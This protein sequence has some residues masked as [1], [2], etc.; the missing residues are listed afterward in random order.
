MTATPAAPDPAAARLL[1]RGRGETALGTSLE[2]AP[3]VSLVL[4]ACD[5]DASPLLLLSDL[6]QHTKNMAADG[7]VSLLF[8][9]TGGLADPLTGARLT[10][11]GRAMRYDDQ[12]ALDRYVARHPSAARY[13]GFGDF[14]L[15]RVSVE[16]GHFVA[17]F[18]RIEWI[19]PEA[20][21]SE[22]GEALAAAETDILEHMNADHA[23]AVGLY[24]RRL[25]GR[26]GDGWRMTGIDPD[27]LDLR[28]GADA[29]R[30]DFAAPVLTPGAARAELVRLAR[31]ARA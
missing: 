31:E 29:A 26:E 9:A 4:S 18:G 7:R 13:A 27:G 15:Y 23:E 6:A 14:H 2:G 22:G 12:A 11:L 24:A 21:R 16:R 5:A 30:L 25:L 3:Y 28:S 10:V 8:D 20:L 1:M 17:G 19:A